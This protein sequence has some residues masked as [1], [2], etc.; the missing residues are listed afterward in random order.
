[1]CMRP[2][3][4]G[5][6]RGSITRTYTHTDGLDLVWAPGTVYLGPGGLSRARVGGSASLARQAME[7]WKCG[8]D[9]KGQC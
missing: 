9:L 2:P 7:E 3:D 4:Q 1:M 6:R 8:Q 5:R